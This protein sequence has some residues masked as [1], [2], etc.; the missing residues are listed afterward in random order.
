MIDASG[1]DRLTADQ[2]M[3]LRDRWVIRRDTRPC[4]HFQLELLWTDKGV[5]I[6]IYVCIH[7]GTEVCHGLESDLST[8]D[9]LP[10][11]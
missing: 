8:E 6:G 1:G 3:R 4:Q 7:C 2:A 9:S 11:Q 5:S 10:S